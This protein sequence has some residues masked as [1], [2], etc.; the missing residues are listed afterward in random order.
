MQSVAEGLLYDEDGD[1][2]EEGGQS[3]APQRTSVTLPALRAALLTADLRKVGA[4][5]GCLPDDVN[6][7]HSSSIKGPMVL[8]VMPNCCQVCI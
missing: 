2:G 1:D 3:A 4:T 6:R 8:Q 7:A 5:A